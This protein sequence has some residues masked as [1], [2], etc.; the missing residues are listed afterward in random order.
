MKLIEQ[1][2]DFTQEAGAA[3]PI[4]LYLNHNV[5]LLFHAENAQGD[6]GT[7]IFRFSNVLELKIGPPNDEAIIGHRYYP[8][9]LR[10]YAYYM[11]E[12][13]DRL[14]EIKAAN[15]VH[16]Y[17][18]EARYRDYMHHILTCKDE[19]IEC[20]ARKVEY[21]FEASSQN[22]VFNRITAEYPDKPVNFAD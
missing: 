14:K 17:H 6:P 16:P 3:E 15:R 11:L 5:I 12:D 9:G 19:V 20:I 1:H 8:L 10:A 22:K 18:D 2:L 13:S 7:G 21:D 4:I